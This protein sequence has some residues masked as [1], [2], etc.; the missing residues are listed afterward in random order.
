VVLEVGDAV[1]VDRVGWAAPSL[2]AAGDVGGVRRAVDADGRKI[3]ETVGEA[4][5]ELIK[6]VG[7]A[8]GGEDAGDKHWV[9][10][11]TVEEGVLGAFDVADRMVHV[12]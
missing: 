6:R 7:E 3:T 8:N 1:G 9:A 4:E 5:E 2:D 10:G 12:R 11:E